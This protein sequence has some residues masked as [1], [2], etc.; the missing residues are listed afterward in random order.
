M[1]VSLGADRIC[2]ILECV[3]IDRHTP[4]FPKKQ[5]TKTVPINNL[6][7]LIRMELDKN[8]SEAI[9][10][11]EILSRDS[12][13][14]SFQKPDKKKILLFL[15]EGNVIRTIFKS[16]V[17]RAILL[18]VR[19]SDGVGLITRCHYCDKRDQGR[20]ITPHG[21][22]TIFFPYSLKRLLEI[23]NNELEGGFTDVIISD[24]HTVAL[25]RPICGWI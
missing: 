16:R 21:L 24:D 11:E 7:E 18:E 17:Y 14:E 13:I 9:W 25:D 12:L 10:L 15:K 23:V 20:R 1:A 22:T 8:F 2:K 19:V 6:L 5:V 4:C 3:Y